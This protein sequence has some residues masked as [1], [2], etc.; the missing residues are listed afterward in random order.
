MTWRLFENRNN[1]KNTFEIECKKIS[2]A[3]AV[4]YGPYV[5]RADCIRDEHGYG[6]PGVER[7]S[8]GVLRPHFGV[9][10]TV[11]ANDYVLSRVSGTI[12]AKRGTNG[13][14]VIIKL[15]TGELC[16]YFYT[17]KSKPIGTK[18]SFGDT[19][20]VCHYYLYYPNH[21][22]NMSHVHFEVRKS[23]SSYDCFSTYNRGSLQLNWVLNPY[24]FIL[25]DDL[26]TRM[27]KKHQDEIQKIFDNYIKNVKGCNTQILNFQYRIAN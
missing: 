13:N 4:A 26:E 22:A 17:G 2:G 12:V 1:D 15:K 25:G 21:S 8:Y 24:T 10:L 5:F 16:A 9:D 19:I 23:G 7:Y 6:N 27:S 20:A 11:M 14:K 18:V 3:K